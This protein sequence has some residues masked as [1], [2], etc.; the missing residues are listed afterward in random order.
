ML[1][2][3]TQLLSDVVGFSVIVAFEARS[4]GNRAGLELAA[5]EDD[6]ELFISCFLP[7]LSLGVKRHILCWTC[8]AN[9]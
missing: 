5:F 7:R 6:L 3:V 4:Q 8:S 1:Y 2:S 9:E